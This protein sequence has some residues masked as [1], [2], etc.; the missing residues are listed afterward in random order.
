M[1]KADTLL[2]TLKL[3]DSDA[4]HSSYFNP[5]HLRHDLFSGQVPCLRTLEIRQLSVN[6]DHPVFSKTLTSLIVTEGSHGGGFEQLLSALEQMTY[7]ECLLLEDAILSVGS[8]TA[9]LPAPSRTIALPL[10][11]FIHL[12]GIAV[13]SANLLRHLYPAIDTELEIITSV[14]QDVVQDLVTSLG[15]QLNQTVPLRTV[16]LAQMEGPKLILSAWRR[17]I[18]FHKWHSYISDRV[19][20]IHL[21]LS[22]PVSSQGTRRLFSE[23]P[24]WSSVRFLQV[25]ANSGQ[26]WAWR[27]I[28]SNMPNLRVLGV[29]HGVENSMLDAL[30]AAHPAENGGT[31]SVALPHLEV[32]AFRY[33]PLAR[34]VQYMARFFHKLI[35]CLILRCNYDLPVLRE[36]VPE[37]V[38]DGYVTMEDDDDDYIRDY[39]PSDY[40]EDRD[41]EDDVGY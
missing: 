19:A 16:C 12:N 9:S 27:D 33:T 11:G 5:L 2:H 15:S 3:S 13:D 39:I 6:W 10:L 21:D 24:L 38:W 32:L 17:D 36:I 18:D 20:P 8:R 14:G 29:L 41:Y 22:S 1:C 23:L 40:Y 30:S 31:P 37:V 26:R 35:D 25:E 4:G 7:L 28:I 34:H